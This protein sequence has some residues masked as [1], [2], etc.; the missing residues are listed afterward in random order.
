MK[1][2]IKN[3]ITIIV[4]AIIAIVIVRAMSTNE[5]SSMSKDELIRLIVRQE[6]MYNTLGGMKGYSTNADLQKRSKKDL[7]NIIA[8]RLSATSL[9][10]ADPNA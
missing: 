2:L 5:F 6:K 9:G 7:I 10:S 3:P 8:T 1:D 4:L